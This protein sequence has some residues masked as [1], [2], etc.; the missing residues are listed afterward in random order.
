MFF[1]NNTNFWIEWLGGVMHLKYTLVILN[2]F[3]VFN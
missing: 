1:N 3:N 2:S